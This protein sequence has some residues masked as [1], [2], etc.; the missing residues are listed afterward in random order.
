MDPDPT[1]APPERPA[2]PAVRP[3]ERVA[4]PPLVTAR[5]L[6]A[7]GVLLACLTLLLALA[8]VLQ[9]R[10]QAVEAAQAQG[11]VFARVLE[12]HATRS[13]DSASLALA[14]LG[15]ALDA[16]SS[17]AAP[18]IGQALRQTLAYT[19]LLR[20]VA[21]MDRQGLVLAGTAAGIEGRR[22]QL[23]RL[24]PLP[25]PG[26]DQVGSFVPARDLQALAEG[27]A[28][29][30]RKGVGF[31]PIVR[32]LTGEKSHLLVVGV[33]NPDAIGNHQQLTLGA[34]GG[35]AMLVSLQGRVLAATADLPQAPGERLP[36]LPALSRY[37]PAVEHGTYVGEGALGADTVVA[38]R[39]SRSRGQFVQVERPLDAVLHGWKADSARMGAA[40]AVIAVVLL[41]VTRMA[42]RNQREREQAQQA[43]AEREH[44]MSIIVGRMQELMF[45]TDLHGRLLFLNPHWHTVSPV[46]T[47]QALG[48]P[49]ADLV[50]PA[51]RSVM[52]ALLAPDGG[53][54]QRHAQVSIATATAAADAV[55]Q[56]EVNVTPLFD[57]TALVGFAG[58]AVDVTDRLA[59]QARLREQLAFTELL[60][61]MLPLP[62]S[63]L[64]AQG[65]LVMANRAWEAFTGRGRHQS[66]GQAPRQWLAPEEADVHDAQ[67]RRLLSTGGTTHYEATRA[68][69]D[70]SRRDQSITKAL[71][72]GPD[73]RPAGVLVAFMDVTE[74]RK[75]ERA[76]REARDAA[77]EASR[78]KS[79]FVANISH[80]LRTPLQSIIGFSE[81]GQVRGRESPK[82]A[83]MFGDIH[84]AGQR[85]LALVN[86]LLD[87]AKIESTVGTFHLERTD[88]RPLARDV[89]REL[90]PLLSARQLRVDI[91]LGDTPLVAK[92]DPMR[93]QQVVRN[94]L[95]NAIRFSQP[96]QSIDLR[97][98]LTAANEVHLSVR[99]RG[100]GIPPG[101]LEKIFEAFVQSSKTKDGSGG[102][103]LGLA[104]CRKIVDAHGGRI[105]AANAPDGGSV[106]HVLLPARGFAETQP[107]GL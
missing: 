80:E 17:G 73:G 100:P 82:L 52:Q 28:A 48:R 5:R 51:S 50:A 106:F 58:S 24:G 97:G 88:L 83:S 3:E 92:V 54:G 84:A 35:A 75:V 26:H 60:F 71:V 96:G 93:L 64:D 74:A 27:G 6:R 36:N 76:V 7:L 65:R 9:E 67:D 102:T 99:D 63:M 11:A 29:E 13:I 43:V 98:E 72:P 40:A 78:A 57:G 14:A 23:L 25:E 44:E 69:P 89:V 91:D 4:R 70:G 56:F 12:E 68:M 53:A 42:A 81:L 62:V 107:L 32:A 2:S 59:G 19:P 95:A 105:G 90:E 16:D 10:R 46:P 38:F 61:E 33:V 66:L 31:V 34:D 85:M 22:L 21:V 94:V 47:E 86:D 39:A 77:E 8:S 41:L 87:V 101:E 55:R 45:R 103:G 1:H 18:R 37:L 20:S 79:E 15:D 49:L 30:V 104:I